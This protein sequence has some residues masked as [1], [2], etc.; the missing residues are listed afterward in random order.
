MDDPELE[1]V[2]IRG[3]VQSAKTA[4]LIAAALGHMAAGRVEPVYGGRDDRLK[5]T[6]AARIVAWGRLCGDE[7]VRE[8]YAAKRPP[9]ARQTARGGRVEVVSARE[10][11]AALM[12]TAEIVIVD[13]LRVFHQDMLGELVDRQAEAVPGTRGFHLDAFLSPFESLPTIVRRPC[14][15][16]GSSKSTPL[17][18]PKCEP[19]MLVRFRGTRLA[20]DGITHPWCGHCHPPAPA[21]GSLHHRRGC[22]SR[23]SPWSCPPSVREPK[24][25]NGIVRVNRLEPLACPQ[26]TCQSLCYTNGV[27]F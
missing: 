8:A 22:G 18:G 4:M 23:C 13:E 11:G 10:G 2:T 24:L 15:R 6:L 12:R 1:Q 21:S 14:S 5:R 9:F 26:C 25:R 17:V 3:S 27:N 20:P 7:Q 19:L 16:G